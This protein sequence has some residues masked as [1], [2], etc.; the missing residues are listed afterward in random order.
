MRGDVV[1]KITSDQSLIPMANL[2]VPYVGGML[3]R[4]MHYGFP[5]LSVYPL[6]LLVSMLIICAA[7]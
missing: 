2:P 3:T 7:L 6:P 1:W 5:I 4:L